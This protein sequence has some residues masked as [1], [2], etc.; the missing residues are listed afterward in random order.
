LEENLLKEILR[1]GADVHDS[2]REGVD[3]RGV[4]VV[5]AL[6]GLAIAARDLLDQKDRV[7]TRFGTH[8]CFL[9]QSARWEQGAATDSPHPYL[10]YE[11]NETSR[12]PGPAGALIFPGG[13]PHAP[14][15]GHRLILL[16][17]S[18]R[19]AVKGMLA[20]AIETTFSPRRGKPVSSLPAGN[21]C[22][23]AGPH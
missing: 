2:Q 15:N 6:E 8:D 22:P 16:V 12:L 23:C 14:I 19:E 7:V 21:G 18:E 17:T 5:E 1:V 10:F 20:M 13:P 4:A 9:S 3:K 11:P